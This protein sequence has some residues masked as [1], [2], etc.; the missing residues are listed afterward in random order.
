MHLGNTT[1]V[2]LVQ[3]K[4]AMPTSSYR[5]TDAD[6]TQEEIDRG[7]LSMEGLLLKMVVWCSTDLKLELK[8]PNE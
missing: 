1:T 7:T 3:E 5:R 6:L 2:K 8:S 4:I